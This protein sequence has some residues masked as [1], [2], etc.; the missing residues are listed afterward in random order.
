MSK[1]LD[2]E[3][4]VK[5]VIPGAAS[6]AQLRDYYQDDPLICARELADNEQ[7]LC[8]TIDCHKFE[9]VDAKVKQP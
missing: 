8:G 6:R 3:I 1:L 4:T 9:I 7:G 5:C 2:L